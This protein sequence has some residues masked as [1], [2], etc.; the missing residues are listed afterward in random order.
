MNDL[1]ALLRERIGDA[2]PLTIAEY[3]ETALTDPTHGY[4]TGR[5]PLGAD[6]DFITAPEISQIFGELCGL[7]LAVAWQN[8]GAPD[9]VTLVELGP[10]RGTLMSDIVRATEN[11]PGFADA[12]RIHLVEASPALR[13]AQEATLAEHDLAVPPM[14]HDR[15]E[16]VPEGPML[17]VANEFF[18]AMPIRQLMR[19]RDYWLER[20]VDTDPDP[21]KETLGYVLVP[22]RDKDALIVP[23]GLEEGEN[24]EF[25]EICPAGQTIAHAI[26]KRLAD[27]GGVALVIDY[28]HAESAA[29]ETLQAVKNHEFHDVLVDP[30]EADLTA[31]V[32]FAAL[33]HA[34][35]T[36]GAQA[37]GPIPQG[38]FLAALGIETRAHALMSTA[39][40]EQQHEIESG[41]KRLVDP[42]QMGSLF[43]VMAI[44]PKGVTPP[45]VFE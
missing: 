21:D 40:A 12:I 17:L 10:G 18:D 11:I 39:S 13:S 22:P 6:G 8:M 32:D 31:H 9:S 28:G 38:H 7:W 25:I 20:C 16:N 27:H 33:S 44:T 15:F 29:G 2:G 37:W 35:F 19:T 34:A 42:E 36:G 30:G 1:L 24:G 26:G 14:W 5:D 41:A 45:A 43:K 23:P 4:Y 3:M